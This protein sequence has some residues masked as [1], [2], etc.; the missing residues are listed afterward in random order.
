MQQ[1]D[2]V[3]QKVVNQLFSKY[4]IYSLSYLPKEAA[5]VRLLD[6]LEVG[7]V[8][9]VKASD[10]ILEICGTSRCGR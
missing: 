7:N 6:K 1:V 8:D 3:V 4:F 9:S 5:G 2:I 10:T